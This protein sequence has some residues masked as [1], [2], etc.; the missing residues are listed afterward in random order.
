MGNAII[1]TIKEITAKALAFYEFQKTTEENYRKRQ[2]QQSKLEQDRLTKEVTRV[3]DQAQRELED[4]NK[5]LEG[6]L[7]INL[8]IFYINY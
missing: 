5:K 3:C 8:D 6:N 2:I 1:L 4:L 7:L